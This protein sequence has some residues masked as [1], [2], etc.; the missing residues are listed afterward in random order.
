MM[1]CL[2]H[3]SVLLVGYLERAGVGSLE[4]VEGAVARKDFAVL[5]KADVLDTEV[6]CAFFGC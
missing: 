1:Y 6:N 4:S 2:T 3:A 5:E